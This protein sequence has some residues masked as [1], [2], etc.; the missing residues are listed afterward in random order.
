MKK[1]AATLLIFS[2][3]VLVV[4]CGSSE[5]R[6]SLQFKYQ[7]GS[8]LTYAQV[9]KRHRLVTVADS[10]IKDVSHTLNMI[11]VQEVRSVEGD[12]IAILYEKDSWEYEKVDKD[13]S[14]KIDTVRNSR[15]LL[16]TILRNGKILDVRS[17]TGE[18][19]PYL[20]YIKNYYEQGLPVF[21]S[22]EVSPGYSW[23]QTTKVILP[24]DVMEASSTY[25][26]KSIV[27][28]AGYDCAVIEYEGNLIIPMEPSADD[29]T[30]A[31]GI[32]HVT[33]T[34]L[35]Y[36]AYREGIV[37][38]QRERWIVRGDH[39]AIRDGE[40]KS[41]KIATETDVEFLLKSITHSI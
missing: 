14:S 33:T 35:I 34:G 38:L 9:T 15:E 1:F 22:G 25:R 17:A 36:F 28:E 21:P 39:Q 24:D 37:V 26:L 23:T 18:E 16:I 29:S 7:E 30:Q 2:A 12:S 19:V 4:S 10:V 3:A 8:K 31:S 41:Y 11:V 27:R 32:D 20:S 6:I 13:D 40:M 5:K